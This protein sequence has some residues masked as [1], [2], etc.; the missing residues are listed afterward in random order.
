LRRARRRPDALTASGSAIGDV[1]V[2][3]GGARSRFWG[4]ILATAL[5]RPLR[6]HAAGES[7]PAFGAAR[8]A[9][10]AVAG[11]D[12]LAVCTPPPLAHVIAPDAAERDALRE[13]R[14]RF[15]DLY[16]ALKQGARP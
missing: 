10:L 4:R 1:A 3:G 6:Y 7:G 8:L 9:R 14:A 5:D 16:P 15:A 11:E 12:P 13:R 2:I